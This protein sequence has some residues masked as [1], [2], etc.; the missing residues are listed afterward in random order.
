MFFHGLEEV[1]G[2]F[3]DASIELGR[4]FASVWYG[5]VPRGRTWEAFFCCQSTLGESVTNL[6][7]LKRRG[8]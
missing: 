7:T 8:L 5:K 1:F 4:L 3:F 2:S 6:V